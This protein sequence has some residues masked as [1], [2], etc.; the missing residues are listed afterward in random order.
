[1]VV[2]VFIRVGKHT[3]NL[4]QVAEILCEPA[5]FGV[6]GEMA[7]A[8]FVRLACGR[9]IVVTGSE[10]ERIRNLNLTIDAGY[11]PSIQEAA[12]GGAGGAV[13][14]C[15]IKVLPMTGSAWMGGSGDWASLPGPGLPSNQYHA[16][17][18]FGLT[19]FP[20]LL[21]GTAE[22]STI[23]VPATSWSKT[24]WANVTPASGFAA[25]VA[26]STHAP[27]MAAVL[28][29]EVSGDYAV[30]LPLAVATAV[31]AAVSRAAQQL[32]LR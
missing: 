15:I 3:V 16:S 28:A 5:P 4:E 25:A 13:M 24:T 19:T 14:R 21:T 2:P 22:S 6:Q 12:G 7:L 9:E 11:Q 32:V 8:A 1:M 27:L 20:E 30:V 17:W 29:F 26:A 10:A 31:A 23:G 18:T